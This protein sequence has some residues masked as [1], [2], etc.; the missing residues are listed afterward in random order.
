[1]PTRSND[2]NR[3]PWYGFAFGCIL[4]V[5][6]FGDAAAGH[7]TDL[8]LIVFG[9]PLSIV[10]VVGVLAAPI[11]WTVV[12]VSLKDRR[13]IAVPVL[14]VH[15]SAVVLLW[16]FGSPS[17]SRDDEWRYFHR[18]E[19]YAPV[20]LWSGIALHVAGVLVAWLIAIRNWRRA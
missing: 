1:M 2:R 14:A 13:L 3:W 5:F 6:A 18:F 20:W 8:P 19:E 7:G 11:W 15:T 4:L 10:P 12:G 16:W 17:V 9:A